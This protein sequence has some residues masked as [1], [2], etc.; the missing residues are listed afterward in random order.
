MPAYRCFF[1]D[2]ADRIFAID[3]IECETETRVPAHADA[4]LA[5]SGHS[6]MEVWDCDWSNNPT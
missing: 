5:A 3:S 2:S 6:G 4:V 1:L